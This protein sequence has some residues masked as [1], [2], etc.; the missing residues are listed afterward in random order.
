LPDGKI[1]LVENYDPN[2]GGPIVY[3]YWS[4]HYLHSSYNNL[5]ISG[6][7]GIRPA[8]EDS[9]Y[10]NPLID[11]TIKYFCISGVNYR[12]HKLT[13]AYDETEQSIMPAQ[14]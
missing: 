5:I 10:I 6:L 1:N 14:A 8:E 7:C 12:G 11:S 9:L 2:V 4:N 13:V 3:Y